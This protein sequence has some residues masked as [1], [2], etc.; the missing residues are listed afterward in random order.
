MENQEQNQIK[1]YRL[2][3]STVETLEDMKIIIDGLD[4]TIS[5]N[6]TSYESVKKYFKEM[7]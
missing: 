2:D 4:L 7:K 3:I 5:E 1:M 6:S